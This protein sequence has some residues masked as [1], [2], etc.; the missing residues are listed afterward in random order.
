MGAAP[1]ASVPFMGQPAP[2]Q[3][4]LCRAAIR[5]AE[6]GRGLPPLLLS[7]IAR[8]ETGRSDPQTGR[9][10]PWPWSINVE[11]R[12]FI[13]DSK[14]EAVNRVRQLQAQGVRSIDV[15]CMQI[16]LMYHPDAFRSLDEAF[17]PLSNARY[18]VDFLT[19]LKQKTGSWEQASAAYH[20][21]S[22][23]EG[24]AY[25]VRVEA[26]LAEEAK[27]SGSTG[28]LP[29]LAPL[30]PAPVPATLFAMAPAALRSLPS[31]AG[32][33]A[34]LSGHFAGGMAPPPR[35][36]GASGGVVMQGMSL[37]AYRSRPVA[38]LSNSVMAG[39]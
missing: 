12:D 6:A 16:N 30:S 24:G 28:P 33:F 3:G 27:A 22:P 26:A 34:A 29:A 14:A 13:F 15:G 17:D 31:G 19:E 32:N 35:M 23:G 36:I 1:F 9:V 37:A 7:A 21:F 25:R 2:E 39:R 4:L 8:V 38:V 18:A 10:N 5:A 20:S 11:G